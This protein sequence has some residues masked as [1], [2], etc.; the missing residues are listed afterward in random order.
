MPS[1][2][3]LVKVSG[4]IL[5]LLLLTACSGAPISQPVVTHITP[6]PIMAAGEPVLP[7]SQIFFSNAPLPSSADLYFDNANWT[8]AGQNN[9]S[10]RSTVLPACCNNKAPAPLW[11][12][13]LGVPLLDA[14]VI[15]DGHVYLLA[16]DG[17]LHVLN[18]QSGQE[19]WR[20]AVG[21][22]LTSDGL[23]LAHGLVYLARAGHFVAALDSRNG[24]E[25]WRFDTEGVVR[26]APLVVGRVLLVASGSN[27]LWCLDA[28][29]GKK[30]WV[31]HSEDTLT[32]FWPTHTTPVV[33][34]NLVYV[35]LGASTEFNALNLRTG[36]KVWEVSLHERMTGGP[37][38]DQ[39][40]GLL[41]VV[42]WSGRIVALDAASGSIRWDTQLASGS[43]S[44]PAL[45]ENLNMLYVGSFG[46]LLYALN[47]STGQ[48]VWRTSIGSAINA[49]PA[50]VQAG[51]QNWVIVASSSGACLIMDART[52]NQLYQ[53]KL[54]ELRAP[55]VVAQGVLYQA[56]LGD[57]GLFAFLL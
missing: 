3:K 27:T 48:F 21:G 57:Q 16:S 52:G 31:F 6:T 32:E 15:G 4:S 11:Y 43:E 47:A 50:V 12:R 8:V 41:Y 55:P 37:M 23:A 26:A 13:S 9:D 10:T 18:L 45:S 28:L 53:W 39:A 22:E 17:Y 42:T 29:T 2:K 19:L 35:A 33:A 20:I 34:N 36:R 54:G 49:S 7:Y 30:Y 14:P 25:Y 24:R 51:E 38:L 44:S 5:F 40:H 1:S 46:G 56:S